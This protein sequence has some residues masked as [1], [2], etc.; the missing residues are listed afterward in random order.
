MRLATLVQIDYTNEPLSPSGHRVSALRG[1]RR[2]C[3]QGVPTEMHLYA[4][5]GHAFGLRTG[6][7]Q[8][9]QWPRLLETWLRTI[10]MVNT[11]LAR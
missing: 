1:E 4:Q 11:A 10:G 5:G 2:Y 8:I 9:A 7:L 6:K 3:H